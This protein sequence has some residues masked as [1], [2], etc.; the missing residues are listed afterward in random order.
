ME[1]LIYLSATGG[2][3]T[4][5]KNKTC[6]V[7]SL[8]RAKLTKLSQIRLIENLKSSV[9]E[10]KIKIPA[11]EGERSLIGAP[12]VPWRC[13]TRAGPGNSAHRRSGGAACSERTVQ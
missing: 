9:I 13:P 4:G 3:E 8:F 2:R 6:S 11:I 5:K 10:K 12:A 1:L 7:L